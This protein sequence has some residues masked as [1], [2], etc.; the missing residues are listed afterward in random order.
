MDTI[1]ATVHPHGCGEHFNSENFRQN[2]YGSSPRVWGTQGTRQFLPDPKRFIP[3]GVGNTYQ[4]T[5]YA[6]RQF[7][8]SPRVWGTPEYQTSG[9]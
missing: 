3:T 2:Q 7:G 9:V 4:F 1:Y 8:S 6:R 5:I